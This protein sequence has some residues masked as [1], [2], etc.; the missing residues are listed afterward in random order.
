MKDIP[1]T[2]APCRKMYSSLFTLRR[3]IDT[4]HHRVK[5]YQCSQCPKSFAY[6]H[7]LREH[8]AK[9]EGEN[10]CQSEG[11]RTY[12]PLLT[13]ML[14]WERTKAVKDFIKPS[15]NVIFLPALIS[16]ASSQTPPLTNMFA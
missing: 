11:K 13:D 5:R 3:H 16:Q 6:A 4:F 1:C 8:V 15:K 7:T 2:F 9:H 14:E 12:V 10:R